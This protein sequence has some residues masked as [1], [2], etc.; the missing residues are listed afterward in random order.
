ML[1]FLDP[2][3]WPIPD[4]RKFYTHVA[5]A[6]I[7]VILWAAY[8]FSWAGLAL[9]VFAYFLFGK[10]GSDIGYHRYFAHQSFKTTPFW[11]WVF[12]ILGSL[13]GNGSS[14]NY[15]TLHYIHHTHAD[16]NLDPHS[17]GRVGKLK[18]WFR[19]YKIHY[20]IGT[21][22]SKYVKALLRDKRQ[23]FLYRHYYKLYY[24]WI[25]SLA[26][27][28]A[29][30]GSWLPIVGLW[31]IPCVILFHMAGA[32]HVINHSWGY[33]NYPEGNGDS[34]N[35]F[36]FNLIQLGSALHNNHHEKPWHYRTNTPGIWHEFDLLG[37]LI[38]RVFM[39]K[40][41]R[42]ALGVSSKSAVT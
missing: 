10:I 17:P 39:D 42:A 24:G 15:V 26:A 16:T 32:T 4:K 18:V 5:I 38:E 23:I 28:S 20:T 12:L 40:A 37:W 3:K 2:D 19:W 27:I 9:G 21:T 25:L 7:G 33:Q 29:A 13:A 30:V 8:Q 35:N 34:T 22:K 36:W 6:H 41:Q 1:H 31:M 11:E 14:I